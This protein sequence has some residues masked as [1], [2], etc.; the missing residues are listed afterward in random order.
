MKFLTAQFA[1]ETNTFSPQPTGRL[2]FEEYGIFH[3]DASRAAPEG[4]GLILAEWR[5][6]AEADGH[7]VVESIAAFA[8]PAGRTIRAVYEELRNE[9][10]RDIDLALPLDG[11]LLMLHGAMAAEGYDDC[12]G[13]LIERVRTL[14]GP[15]VAIGVELD[16]HCH[17]TERMRRS[18]DVI[19]AF[20]EYP[21]ID[22]VD[23]A[24][25]LYRL[26]LDTAARRIRPVTAVHD[27]RM[28][29]LWHTTREPMIGFVKRMQALEGRDGI[30]SVSFGH[31]FPWG[32][33]P[34]SGAKLWVVTDNDP[35]LAET[36]VRQL[37]RELWDIR[38][39]TRP[40]SLSI[41]AALDR[42][43]AIDGGPVVLAD[44]GDNPG[45]GAP[46]DST[47]VLQRLI[48]RGIG[49]AV[50]GAFWDL[51]AI[52][53]CRDAG[54]GAAMDLRLGGKCGPASGNPID[55]KVTVR[56]IAEHH[57]Q[58]DLDGRTPMGTA[59]W[60]ETADRI[61]LLLVSVRGQVFNPD[62]FT[63]LGIDLASRK[64]II[65]KSTQHFHAG[66]APLAREVLYV[67]SPGALQLEFEA[68]PYRLRD[69][70]YW[71]RL[72]DPFA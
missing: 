8:Q 54:V 53:L 61:S 26:T 47:F 65:V 57:S 71:P 69:L 31:G 9:I 64:L 10:L 34:E 42:A 70:T 48:D 17:F 24:R 62:A 43:L 7:S 2:A 52:H 16:L 40:I 58:G 63:G 46:S 49:N 33:V 3:G 4:N 38:E 22:G 66:F 14:V 28:V 39:E 41:D 6:L 29:G 59:V 55:L 44:V 19:I 15:D 1:T 56:A 37:G 68:I 30:L 11:I 72:A 18:A 21:H 23:R 35:A 25:E 32:D 51:G 36:T 27:C 12:E 20:K 13:D 67:T 45:G 50:L 5:R 60:I